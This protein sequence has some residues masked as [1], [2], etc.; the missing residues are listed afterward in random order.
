M[1]SGFLVFALPVLMSCA[2]IGL[3]RATPA[4]GAGVAGCYRLRLG[5]WKSAYPPGPASQWA[6]PPKAIR[7]VAEKGP[8]GPGRDCSGV[9][10]G[11]VYLCSDSAKLPR[12]FQVGCWSLKW[13]GSL[14]LSWTTMKVGVRVILNRKASSWH[15]Y[16]ESTSDTGIG[17]YRCDAA[18]EPIHCD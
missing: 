2:A 14:V 5:E 1:K 9:N 16:A 13:D 7:L 6:S 17:A 18:L 10:G 12:Y 8:G 11:T 3:Q 15:G 4:G